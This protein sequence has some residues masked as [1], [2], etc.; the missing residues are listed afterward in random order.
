MCGSHGGMNARDKDPVGYPHHVPRGSSADRTTKLAASPQP[1]HA[2]LAQAGPRRGEATGTTA[3]ITPS[4]IA[5]I[6]EPP[7]L[8]WFRRGDVRRHRNGRPRR[9]QKVRP[10][11]QSSAPPQ[12]WPA[13]AGASRSGATC[14][15]R[16]AAS[17]QA[18]PAQAALAQ[19]ASANQAAGPGFVARGWENL[20]KAEDM[21]AS[22]P[23]PVSSSYA[24]RHDAVD[25]TAQMPSKWP[26]AETDRA[27]AATA[28]EKALRYFSIAGIRRSRCSWSRDGW[29][30]FSHAR[31]PHR[32]NFRDVLRT[33]ATRLR[34][35][36]RAAF[37]E[38]FVARSAAAAGRI[39]PDWRARTPT[40]PAQ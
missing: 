21:E 29:R 28:G 5:G 8:A 14:A 26:L 20:P 6:S 34:L 15:V 18:T 24:E 31:Q 22:E 1:K 2:R 11:V 33:M 7:A 17:A 16:K 12:A 4:S 39:S 40:D 36:R 3:S 35:R 19:A 32:S 23:A 30:N 37:D 27:T 10:T 25:T 38:F 9:R 13:A